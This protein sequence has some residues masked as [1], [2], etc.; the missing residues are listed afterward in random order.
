M[1]ADAAA[2]LRKPPSLR[3]ARDLP[4]PADHLTEESATWWRDVLSEYDLATHQVPVLQAACEAWDQ[5]Q[6]A[7]RQV[8]AEGAV[9]TDRFGQPKQHPAAKVALD[10]RT[11][12]AR[13]VRELALD[14]VAPDARAPRHDGGR[15]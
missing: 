5:S 15:Q 13:L 3:V 11:Q 9:Y 14:G 4:E 12:F 7:R 6:D 8:E 2:I 10:A 1:F